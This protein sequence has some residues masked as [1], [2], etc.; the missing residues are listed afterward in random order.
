MSDNILPVFD[1]NNTHVALTECG[2]LTSKG[3]G[4]EN[5]VYKCECNRRVSYCGQQSRVG[6]MRIS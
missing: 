5:A 3:I 6:M 1:M 2:R 4:S